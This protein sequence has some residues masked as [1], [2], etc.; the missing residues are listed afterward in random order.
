MIRP[1]QCIICNDVK[2]WYS[3]DI[4]LSYK[5]LNIFR[6]RKVVLTYIVRLL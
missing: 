5:T 1:K 2:I 6:F 3:S 4:L